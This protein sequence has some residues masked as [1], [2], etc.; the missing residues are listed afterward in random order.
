MGLQAFVI[1]CVTALHT[2]F[3]LVYAKKVDKKLI[4]G[5]QESFE[6]E[7]SR[8]PHPTFTNKTLF[9]KILKNPD[10]EDFN[11]FLALIKAHNYGTPH[12]V[13]K[14]RPCRLCFAQKIC[15]SSGK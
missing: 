11:W 12:M 8:V 6:Q 5:L 2:L 1:I 13:G 3:Q 14:L 7:E 4:W 10:F 15:Q 9:T